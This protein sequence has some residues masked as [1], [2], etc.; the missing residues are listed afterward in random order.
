MYKKKIYYERKRPTPS[1]NSF[2]RAAK[3][4][5]KR[6]KFWSPENG[7]KK[8]LLTTYCTCDSDTGVLSRRDRLQS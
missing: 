4:A 1:R 7:K 5:T 3:I 6:R 2:I 8:N